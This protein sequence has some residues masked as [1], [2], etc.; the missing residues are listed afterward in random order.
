FFVQ[1][2]GSISGSVHEDLNG[3]GALD[4][5]EGGVAGVVIGL[6]STGDQVAD[7]T[8]T[9]SAEGAYSFAGLAP[10]SYRV[11]LNVPAGY[12]NTGPAGIDVAVAAGSNSAAAPFFIRKPPAPGS[13]TPPPGGT[14]TGSGSPLPGRCANKKFG[15]SGAD[16]LL[17]TAFGD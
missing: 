12:E 10:R 3:N 15:T 2:R 7:Q 1:Q 17:G 11:L 6:D 9:T 14:P 13:G 5:G 4:S 8:T 16:R